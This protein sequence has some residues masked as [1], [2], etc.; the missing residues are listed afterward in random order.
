MKKTK[1]YINVRQYIA[2]NLYITFLLD[3]INKAKD[4]SELKR[5]IISIYEFKNIKNI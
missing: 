1:K 5:Q 2:M 3:K 4:I